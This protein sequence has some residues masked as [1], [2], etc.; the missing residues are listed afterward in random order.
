MIDIAILIH[1]I[2]RF[3]VRINPSSSCDFIIGRKSLKKHNFLNMFPSHFL[4]VE[5]EPETGPFDELRWVNSTRK[6]KSRFAALPMT[7]NLSTPP[8]RSETTVKGKVEMVPQIYSPVAGLV[9]YSTPAK[10]PST[11]LYT[12]DIDGTQPVYDSPTQH[13]ISPPSYYTPNATNIGPLSH[14]APHNGNTSTVRV[15]FRF[16]NF[17]LIQLLSPSCITQHA[18]R[19]IQELTVALFSEIIITYGDMRTVEHSTMESDPTSLDRDDDIS[20]SS[21]SSSSSLSSATATATTSEHSRDGGI[22]NGKHSNI[23]AHTKNTLESFFTRSSRKVVEPPVSRSQKNVVGL[24][25]NSLLVN[26]TLI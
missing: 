14:A 21:S 12:T 18:S 9:T 2:I 3:S 25:A 16:S 7:N 17:E 22:P 26:S 4:A 23:R 13:V 6:K 24:S 1:K 11:G 8:A 19:I 5:F 15:A 10:D 20:T